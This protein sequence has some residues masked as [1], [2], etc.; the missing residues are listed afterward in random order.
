MIRYF[1]EQ[2]YKD[3]LKFDP[4]EIGCETMDTIKAKDAMDLPDT[5]TN[6][7]HTDFLEGLNLVEGI[8]NHGQ[9]FKGEEEISEQ[10]DE[11]LQERIDKDFLG[12][13][14]HIHGINYGIGR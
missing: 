5:P 8:T 14:Q 12:M 7:I 1:D 6:D 4:D 13:N 2:D 10:D 3:L 9:L 11:D